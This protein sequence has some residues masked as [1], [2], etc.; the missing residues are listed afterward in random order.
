MRD[1]ERTQKA[2]IID[3]EGFRQVKTLEDHGHTRRKTQ[4]EI[5]REKA[6]DQFFVEDNKQQFRSREQGGKDDLSLAVRTEDGRTVELD[7]KEIRAL[8]KYLEQQ[9]EGDLDKA[10]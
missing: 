6:M 7:L 9:E 8:E 2:H 3:E 4:L 5:N 10:A 1:L